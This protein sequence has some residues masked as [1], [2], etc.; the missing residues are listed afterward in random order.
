MGAGGGEAKRLADG[1]EGFE[2][3]CTIVAFWS[4]RSRAGSVG[5]NTDPR[6]STRVRG[7]P[8]SSDCGGSREANGNLGRSEVERLQERYREEWRSDRREV[9]RDWHDMS[10]VP[11]LLNEILEAL[12]PK[13]GKK[14]IDATANGGGHVQAL[15][16]RGAE[17]LA[18]E[19][20][21]QLAKAL[22]SKL[23]ALGFK[24]PVVHDSYVNIVAIAK[25]HGFDQCDGVLF[26]LGFSSWQ[27]E[28]AGRGL[29]F[30]RDEFLNMRYN[31]AS[32]E[33]REAQNTETAADI[34]NGWSEQELADIFKEYGEERF[35]GRIAH[36]IVQ[37]RQKSAISRTFQLI[38]IVR[39]AVP[40]RYRQGRIHVATRIFQALRIAVNHEFE[41]LK[42]GIE[43]AV[44]ILRNEG[45]L[46]IISFHS[47]ED[48]I[49]KQEFKKMSELNMINIINKKVI[50]ASR[51]EIMANRRARSAKLRVIEKL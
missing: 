36:A 44:N 39:E 15:L 43:G 3:V 49:V 45:R 23:Q 48:R 21:E 33:K 42:A 16:E 1:T 30:M 25:E 7:A 50:Q 19:W 31:V 35:D 14:F 29:S 2:R 28:E 17:V 13:P 5:K 34:L 41:N 37:A 20:D 26:D 40:H 18:I 9:R 38:E 6:K 10:H 46:A 11:V 32:S 27:I 8:K 12:Q 47:L 22:N 24:T 51:E 4:R